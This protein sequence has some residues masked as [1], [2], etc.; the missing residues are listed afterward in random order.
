LYGLSEPTERWL[1]NA[2]SILSHIA[3][4]RILSLVKVSSIENILSQREVKYRLAEYHIP[5]T[6]S[7]SCEADRRPF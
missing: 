6:A 5:G 2:I 1:A 4:Q 3:P 7:I